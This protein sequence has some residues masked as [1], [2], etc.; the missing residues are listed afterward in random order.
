MGEVKV[1]IKEP[2]EMTLQTTNTQLTANTDANCFFSFFFLAW[3]ESVSLYRNNQVNNDGFN[4]AAS[5][6]EPPRQ[7]A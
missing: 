2:R 6:K 4:I 7:L 3:K 5:R 1:D